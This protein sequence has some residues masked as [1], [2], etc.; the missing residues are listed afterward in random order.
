MKLKLTLH[1]EGGRTEDVVV[2]ADAGNSVGDVAAA[3]ALAD[4]RGARSSRVGNVTLRIEGSAPRVIPPS[5]GLGSAG[6][7]SGE[8]VSIIADGGQFSSA[9]PA[10]GHAATLTVIEGPDAGSSFPLQ[11]GSNQIGRGRGNDV[12]LTDPMVS[13]AHARI[14]VGD[15]LD[16]ADLGSSNGIQLRGTTVTRAVIGANDVAVIGD[17]AF[18]VVQHATQAAHAVPSPTVEFNRSPRLDPVVEGEELVAPSPPQQP[19]HARFPVIPLVAPIFM[20]SIM[21]AITRNVT[22][23][24][25]VALSPI[26]MVGSFFENRFAGKKAFELGTRQFRAGLKDL[27]IQ[28]HYAL[29]QEGIG[30]R[31][32]YPA[33]AEVVQAVQT[34]DPLL[35]TRRPDQRAF[36]DLRLGLGPRPSRHTIKLPSSNTTSPELWRE[37]TDIPKRYRLVENVPVVADL[38]DCGSVGI[39][40][41]GTHA[42]AAARSAVLQVCG[43]HSPAEVVLCALISPDHAPGWEWLKWLPH[44]SSDHCPLGVEQLAVSNTAPLVA[45]LDDFVAQREAARRGSES[46][47]PVPRVVLLVDDTASMDRAQVVDLMERGGSVG[48]HLIWFANSQAQLPAACRVFLAAD[49]TSGTWR[50]GD[51]RD[52]VAADDIVPDLLD[53]AAAETAAR[54]LSP[55]VDAGALVDDD[56]DIPRAVTFLNLVDSEIASNPSTVIGSWRASYSLPSDYPAPGEKRKRHRDDITLRAVIGSTS[57]QPFMLDLRSQGPHALVG[58]TTG[59]GKSEFLQTWVLGMA[60]AHSPDRV[61]FLFVDYKG[62]AAFSECTNLPHTVGLVTDLSPHLVRRALVSLKAELRYREELLQHHKANDLVALEKKDIAAAPPSL[63]IIVDEFAALVKEVPDFVD[64]VVDVAQRGRSLGLHLILATQRPAGVIR[65][66]LRANT[67]LRIALR[68]ADEADS[69]DVVGTKQAALF[70]PIPGRALAKLGPGRL[71]TFQTAYVGGWTSNE[72]PKPVILVDELRIGGGSRWEP[73]EVDDGGM[74]SADRGP[75]DLKRI[76]ATVSQAAIDA[77]IPTPRKPWQAELATAYELARLRPS[78]TDRE[79][80]FGILDDPDRQ[81]QTS[82]QF[83]PDRDGNMAVFGTGGAGKSAFLRT[84]AVAAGLSAEGPCQVYGLDFGSRG[85]SMLEPLPHVGSIIGG[86]DS[87]RVARLL[88]FLRKTIDDRAQRYAAARAGS[89]TEYRTLAGKPD[90]PRLLV[91][92][93]GFG[94]FRTAYESGATQALYDM[95]MGLTADGR[96]LGVHF[97]ITADRPSIVPGSLG[98]NIQKR[99][100]L[101]L[102]QEADYGYFGVPADA[103]SPASPAG[104][105]FIDGYEVQVAVLGGQPSTAR[106]SAAISKLADELRSSGRWSAAPEIERLA[107]H[108]ELAALPMAVDGLPCLGIADESLAPIG[109]GIDEPLLVC[110]PPQANRATYVLGLVQSIARSRP[111]VRVAL[112]APRASKLANAFAWERALDVAEDVATAARELTAQGAAMPIDGVVLENIPD[113]ANGPADSPLQELVRALTAA[114]KFVIAEAD[115]NVVTTV[116]GISQTLR[117]ARHGLALQPD[118]A[119]GDNIFRTSFPKANRAEFPAGRGFY[120]RHGRVTKVQCAVPENTAGEAG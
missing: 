30:R 97:V 104:R 91:L 119:E 87:E 44:T 117:A 77:G 42:D 64:G 61:N 88:H 21:F 37:L 68:M 86:D 70:E 47:A 48:V 7:Q 19:G 12:R 5:V 109:F 15:Q 9:A 105:G 18:R 80:V 84:L 85:L 76:V 101:R 111:D 36:L 49:P 93:D 34:R 20:A 115:S 72:P 67:N 113:F 25:F 45:A 58:G 50:V 66:N 59:A 98:S 53:A 35:W 3:I 14:N 32:E 6:L 75:N 41:P 108:V 10:A 103:I 65:D 2:T 69:Q 78:R 24:V 28:M 114:G 63:I 99:L 26:M 46:K 74:E 71:T 82:V 110:G 43:L 89:I 52:G 57:A 102:A 83:E 31:A 33:T 54:L 11:F 107:E 38:E 100:V 4:P 79:L 40:G 8:R 22:S 39:A 90:E 13:K 118:Q 16:I 55:V 62:G 96:P 23:I 27:E 81:Q 73:P 95:F 60:A 17:T 120:V 94:A 56:S 51:V 112:F 116:Y 106:Q 29:D 92:L 1:L